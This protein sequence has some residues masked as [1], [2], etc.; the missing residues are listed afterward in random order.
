MSQKQEDLLLELFLELSPADRKRV[1]KLCRDLIREAKQ[2][3]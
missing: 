2:K 1:I 3:K